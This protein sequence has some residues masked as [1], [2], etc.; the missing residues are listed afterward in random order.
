MHE[1][2]AGSVFPLPL[3]AYGPASADGLLAT[4]GHRIDMNPIN[5]VATSIF[6]LAIVHTFVAPKFGA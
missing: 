6:M 3:D 5:I 2:P 4:L 1:L